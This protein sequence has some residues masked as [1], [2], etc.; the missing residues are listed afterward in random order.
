MLLFCYSI[1]KGDW[2][3]LP[4]VQSIEGLMTASLIIPMSL[5]SLIA[6]QEP[7]FIIP[8][9]LPLVILYANHI[10]RISDVKTVK[11]SHGAHRKQNVSGAK[12]STRKLQTA[13]IIS[14]ALLTILYGFVH[15][16]GVFPL[17][18]HLYRE[19]NAKPHLTHLHIYTSHLYFLPTALLQLRN[20]NRVYLSSSSHKYT[21]NQDFHLYEKGDADMSYI[22]NDLASKVKECDDMYKEKKVPFRLYYAFPSSHLHDFQE[23]FSSN[24]RYKL[25]YHQ[26][27]SFFPHLSMEKLPRIKIPSGCLTNP[28]YCLMQ[29][30]EKDSSPLFNF[31][32][33][34]G[35]VLMRVEGDT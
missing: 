1:S 26:V 3:D 6:H 25:K 4:R 8:V 31:A 11:Q 34:F 15:Q 35:L 33:L 29:L 7:R 32:E 5:L 22:Y 27:Q 23:F 21:L 28:S 2:L 14:N 10:F 16:A 9:I 24:N 17:T 30:L 19:L 18:S 13:W 12:R 20:S